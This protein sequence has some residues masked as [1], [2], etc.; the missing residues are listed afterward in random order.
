MGKYYNVTRTP[1]SAT[2]SKGKV[3]CFPPKQWAEIADEVESSASIVAYVKKKFLT[4]AS[5]QVVDVSIPEAPSSTLP[6]PVLVPVIVPPRVKG[7]EKEKI[8]LEA[9]AS[10]VGSETNR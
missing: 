3:V 9:S 7:K 4:R 6:P 5:S 1:L 8:V 10:V 2:D